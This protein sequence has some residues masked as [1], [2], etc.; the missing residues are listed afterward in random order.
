MSTNR[1]SAIPLRSAAHDRSVACIGGGGVILF[2]HGRVWPDCCWTPHHCLVHSFSDGPLLPGHVAH[3]CMHSTRIGAF[4]S[5]ILSL[6]VDYFLIQGWFFLLFFES[7]QTKSVENP[8]VEWAQ[9]WNFHKV[10]QWKSTQNDCS[11]EKFIK[12]EINFKKWPKCDAP[13]F[14]IMQGQLILRAIARGWREFLHFCLIFNLSSW[15]VFIR[16]KGVYRCSS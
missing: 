11:K 13:L 5:C 2:A 7:A 9:C 6:W 8:R 14:K 10:Q 4:Y 16:F 3:Q 15:N 1:H 12:S